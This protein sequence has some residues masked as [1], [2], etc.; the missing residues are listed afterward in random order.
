MP[1]LLPTLIHLHPQELTDY[2]G[3]IVWAARYTAYGRPTR[4]N[5]DTHQILD[6]PLRRPVLR[7]KPGCTTT[8]IA[9]TSPI[10]GAT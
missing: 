6:Q 7:P 3:D 10:S 9:T 5:R 2:S 1:V 8:G 4:L